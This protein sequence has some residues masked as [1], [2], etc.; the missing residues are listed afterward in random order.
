VL[1]IDGQHLGGEACDVRHC[2]GVAVFDPADQPLELPAL[3][4]LVGFYEEGGGFVLALF[5]ASSWHN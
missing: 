5:V 1:E 4:D 3:E 2:E